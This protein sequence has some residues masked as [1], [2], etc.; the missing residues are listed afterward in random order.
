VEPENKQ[1]SIIGLFYGGQDYETFLQNEPEPSDG[2]F[3]A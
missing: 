2:P 3:S 1:V